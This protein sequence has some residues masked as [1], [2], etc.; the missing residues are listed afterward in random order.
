MMR[1][2]MP[3]VLLSA[4]LLSCP[5]PAP[6]AP[7]TPWGPAEAGIGENTAFYTSGEAQ[8]GDSLSFCLDWGDG[9]TSGWTGFV[10]PG[11][12]VAATRVWPEPGTYSIRAQARDAGGRESDWSGTFTFTARDTT[13]HQPETPALPT[14]PDSAWGY[15]PAEFRSCATDPD[16]EQIMFRF[17][18]AGDTGV[19]AGPVNSGDTFVGRL[20]PTDSGPQPV[21]C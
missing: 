9:T 14:G 16:G 2:H 15:E 7:A 21:R 20:C 13:N 19:W 11:D 18:G 4:L 8:S 5:K 6:D 12:T 1:L 17:F 3:V 10:R